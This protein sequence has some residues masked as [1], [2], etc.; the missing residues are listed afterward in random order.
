M[1]DRYTRP[2][3]RKIWSEQNKFARWLEV[4]M[5]ACEAW[6]ELG[7]IPKEVPPRI[8]QRASF[9]I[10]RID[11][12]ESV[13]RHDVI[14][15]VT[16]VGETV[17]EDSKYIHFGLTSYDVVDTALSSLLKEAAD[18]ILEDLGRLSASLKK[19]ALKHKHTIMIGRTHGIHAEPITFGLKLAGW[20]A[21]N[22]RNIERMERARRVVSFGKLSGAVGTYGNID[23]Y[24][25]KYVCERMGL[26]PAPISTQIIQRDRHAEYVAALAM[27][28][29]SLEKFAT[30]IRSLQR[31]EIREVEEP[32]RAGQ[33]GSSA[34]PHK[35]N[36]VTVEQI[37]GLARVLRGNLQAALENVPLWNERDISNSSVERIILPDSTT[38]V[39]YMLNKFTDVVEN[40]HIYPDR[41]RQNL[42]M[43]GGLVFSQ[44]VLLALVDS[45]M[46]REDAYAIVQ[47]LAMK[48]WGGE[49][50]FRDLVVGDPRVLRH[51]SREQVESC[52]DPSHDTKH[53]DFIF[54][55]LGLVAES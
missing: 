13:V 45:G 25:E 53:T 20:Y 43:T 32:F 1:I 16:A 28:G 49:G 34:M 30:E 11:E 52:F 42:E 9:D 10:E 33:K 44:K 3:M 2:A 12:I 50:K 41:M 5:L 47:E 54:Q 21:E 31:T 8:R 51:L 48:G 15:F 14:A 27:I 46:K 23:P 18:V 55:R 35:R 7:Q 17:G 36:P 37:C 40:M 24:V 38:L 39:D 6:A 29:T 26:E 22:L 4:E 19:Q